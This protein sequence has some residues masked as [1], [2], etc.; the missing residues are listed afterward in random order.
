LTGRTPILSPVRGFQAA[1]KKFREATF[2]SLLQICDICALWL[3]FSV[4]ISY[5]FARQISQGRGIETEKA[6]DP[7]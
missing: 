3:S 1:V 2:P 4:P 7:I 5:Y 6:E